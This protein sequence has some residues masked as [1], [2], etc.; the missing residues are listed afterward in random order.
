MVGRIDKHVVLVLVGACGDIGM[1]ELE[2]DAATEC[3]GLLE[4]TWRRMRID[5]AGRKKEFGV[6]SLIAAVRQAIMVNCAG[7]DYGMLY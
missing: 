3:L 7:I 4:C 2:D 5:G 1:V 6:F